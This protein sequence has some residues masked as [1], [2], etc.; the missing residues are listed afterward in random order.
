[1]LRNT[2]LAS[3]TMLL[4]ALYSSPGL[5]QEQDSLA[6]KKIIAFAPGRV[7]PAYLREHVAEIEELP[8]DGLIISVRP[9]NWMGR[10]DK[11]NA[12]WFGGA[13][14][15]REDYTQAIADLKA[16]K[17]KRFTD[18]FMDLPITVNKDPFI[19]G[20]GKLMPAPPSYRFA[21]VDWFDKD[22]AQVAQNGAVA[23]YVAREGGLKGLLIDVE[24]YADGG[25][26]WK[27]PFLY[28]TYRKEC[29]AAGVTPR[30]A[31]EC[32]AMVRQRGQEFM[33]AIGEVYP[34][35]TIII[36]Q[37][38]GWTGREMVKSFVK[39]MLERRGA[40][41]LI[42]GG[43][44]GYPLVTHKEFANLRKEAEGGH[45][46]DEVFRP[47]QYGFGVW[48]D[49][50]P[51]QHGGWHTDPADFHKNY[52]TPLELE[53]T[54]HGAL[55]ASDRYVWLY[56]WHSQ[57]WCNPHVRQKGK[58]AL[59]VKQC[60]LCPHAGIPQEYLDAISNCRKPHDLDWAPKLRADRFVYFDDTVLVEGSEISPQSRN[61]LEN[62]GLEQWTSGQSPA[63]IGWIVTGQGPVVHREEQ[64]L[65]SGK[66]SVRLTTKRLQG[67]VIIDQ[68]I[69]VA[70]LAGRTVTF[71]SWIKTS[72]KG[73]AGVQIL[74]YADGM[75]EVSG[76][77]HPG[78][79]E[80]HL[81]SVTRTIRPNATNKVRFRLSAH[82]P[83]LKD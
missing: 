63:P 67:H 61:I 1:M 79:G 35:I 59:Q 8:I 37:N 64:I 73:V 27:C 45:R 5:A 54:L 22:W 16:T 55:T 49:H 3:A 68:H 39:G 62:T 11:R 74:D 24:E 72:L 43:E 29:T 2:T 46:A 80:W 42:D 75:W 18:N 50:K 47:L 69:P 23:A 30:S 36:I 77:G 20:T 34:D 53:N 58:L 19:A 48:I 51:R 60:Q 4:V 40:A 7:D 12:M 32:I 33:E 9:D 65:K 81:A 56:I 28:E 13:R 17:C 21:N 57:L 71:G 52:R 78:D 66:C 31:E 25:G 76:G 26:L 70:D 38:T 44:G 82:I 14:Y 15:T 10:M 83:Y 41:T 6:A